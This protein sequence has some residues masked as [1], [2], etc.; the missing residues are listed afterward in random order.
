M[1]KP[2]PGRDR[3]HRFGKGQDGNPLLA[4]GWGEPEAGFVWSEGKVST[5]RVPLPSPIAELSLSVWGYSPPGVPAQDLLVFVNGALR[6]HFVVTEK[7]V[8]RLQGPFDP[9]RNGLEVAFF[10]PNATSPE[11][12]E[13]TNDKRQLGIA[14]A[15][16]QLHETEAQK[17]A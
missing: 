14:L 6:G 8:H 5:L 2:P 17:A 7:A 11:I 16:I 15:A 10:I 3:I 1:P 12:A 9:G 4:S 13:R